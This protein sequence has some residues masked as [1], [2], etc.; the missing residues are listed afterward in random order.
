MTDFVRLLVAPAVAGLALACGAADLDIAEPTDDLEFS[1]IEGELR[2]NGDPDRLVVYTNNV[3]NMLFDWKDLVHFMGEE[4]LRP[5]LFLVQ[6]V[7][8]KDE[9]DRLGAFM[10]KRLGVRYTGVVA[11]NRPDDRRFQAQIVPRPTVTTGVIFRAGRFE[12]L[13]RDTWMPFGRGFES[14]P[15]TCDARS[16]HSGYES[17]RVKL[18]DKVAKKNVLAVS[19]R[20][21]TWHPCSTKNAFEIVQGKDSGPNAHGGLGSGAALHLVAGDFNDRALEGDGDYA[22]WYREMNGALG[23]DGCSTGTMAGFTDP[24]FTACAG[25]KRCV[26]NRGGIDH[27]FVR[28]SDGKPVRTSH[29]GV[30]SP[31]DA[32]RASVQSTGGDAASNLRPR[33][34][35]NDQGAGYSQHR[36]RKAYVFYE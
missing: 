24:L 3:E 30:I 19:L 28:R 4:P 5:D 2:T 31:A 13:D 36:A 29:F 1:T 32:H 26:R 22:C 23:K 35:Y 10:T 8:S 27:I 33:D 21:W 25:E 6:Q 17:I 12:L 9:L 7:T 34:G 15:Q 14:Q 20:H 18:F 16:N 11:Q